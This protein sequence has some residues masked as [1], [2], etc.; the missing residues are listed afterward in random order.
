M[1]TR[2]HRID[3]KLLHAA[4][5]MLA[6]LALILL[7]ACSRHFEQAETKVV[8][9]ARTVRTNLANI[10]TLQ[11]EFEPYQ[12]IMVHGKVSG[13][14]SEIRVDIG[15]RV[16]T[17]ELIALVEVPELSD[18]LASA[19]AAEQRAQSDHDI[20]HLNSDR[21]QGVN[22]SQPN[23]VAQQDLDDASAKDSATAAALAAAKA[24]A[25]RY[26][27]LMAYTKIVAP[28]SGVI[29][30]RF[31][32]LGSL[33][34]AGT[35]SN[36]QPLV[37]LAEDDLLRLRF[38]VPEAETPRI[39]R[40]ESVQVSVDALHRVFTGKIVR[41]TWAIDRSTRTMLTEVDVPNTDGSLKAGMY[42]SIA[43]PLEEVRNVLVV[44]VQALSH[45]ESATVFVVGAN[46]VVEERTVSVGLR[47]ADL[48]EIR[49]GLG[50]GDSVITGDRGGLHPGDTVIAKEM[51][52]ETSN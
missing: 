19:V 27:A 20:A 8:P 11:A 45:G 41:D 16:R 44:P 34:Q 28:F 29:T 12:D 5:G 33:I 42:A 6:G 30:K 32:D 43:L 35:A 39:H 21:L 52:P 10:M 51:E 9:V 37:E 48:A 3:R 1:N 2:F 7:G 18:Q 22:R 31:V 50:E 49:S 24:E 25:D 23:L 26:A 4:P 13:Y 47:T 38:P 40:G 14:V 46:G 36:S 17:G 15:D